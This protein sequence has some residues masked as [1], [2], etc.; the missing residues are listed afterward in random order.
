M[1]LQFSSGILHCY[2]IA[3]KGATTQKVSL[4]DDPNGNIT[5][6]D[7]AIGRIAEH[8]ENA[9]AE[10]KNIQTQFETA[11]IEVQKMSLS[12]TLY[13]IITTFLLLTNR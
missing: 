10:L 3:L 7:N 1:E 8:I 5:R 6:I 13:L 9:Q 2:E 12:K 4:G 11:Q